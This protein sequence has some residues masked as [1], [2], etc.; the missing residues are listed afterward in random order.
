MRY[1]EGISNHSI[2]GPYI[3]IFIFDLDKCPDQ[4]FAILIQPCNPNDALKHH[5]ASLKDDF[6]S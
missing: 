3:F 6:I 5:F 1:P 4:L 2:S